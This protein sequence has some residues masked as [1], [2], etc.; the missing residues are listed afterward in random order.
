MIE[1]ILKNCQ[2][3]KSSGYAAAAQGTTNGTELD[4]ASATE[5]TFDSVC[6][7]ATLSEV[8]SASVVSLKAY[9][10]DVSGLGSGA[11]YATTYATVTASGNDTDNNQLVLDC[12]KPGIRYIRPDLIIA[13]QDAAIDSIIA[14]RYNGRLNPTTELSA[15]A[16][17]AISVNM[18]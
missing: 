4:L 18:A 16:D 7:I 17:G 11:A 3:S 14:I 15:L 9:G 10:G 5:G 2:I 13:T 8:T 6:F 12:V 1:S